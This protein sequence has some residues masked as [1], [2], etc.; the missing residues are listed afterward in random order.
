LPNRRGAATLDYVLLM[1]ALASLGGLSLY[2][3]SRV[4]VLAYDMVCAI[5]AWPFS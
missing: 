5:I 2:L 3:G 1:G 4:I